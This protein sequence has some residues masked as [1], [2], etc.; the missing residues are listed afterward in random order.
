MSFKN[1]AYAT[2]WEHKDGK[3][4]YHDGRI[5]TSKKYNG[6][7]EED[8]GAWVRFIGD[9]KTKCEK[10]SDKRQRIKIISCEVTNRWDREAKK[11]YVNFAIFD[12]ELVDDGSKN[13]SSN[14]NKK[15][16][17]SDNKSDKS[18]ES[19]N[20]FSNQNQNTQNNNPLN[21][22]SPEQIQALG[23]LLNVVMSG[24]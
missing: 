9:A 7:Y 2:L 20:Q 13:N 18:D 15:N 12:F 10:L 23:N 6:D 24:N 16:D 3:G 11:E 22:F 8:F 19:D 14:K 21:S 5:S 1:G 17:T 4:N